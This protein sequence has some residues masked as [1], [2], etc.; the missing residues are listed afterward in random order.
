MQGDSLGLGCDGDVCQNPGLIASNNEGERALR[1]AATSKKDELRD[2]NTGGHRGLHRFPESN[3]D[4]GG[5]VALPHG[6][7][8]AQ[9]IALAEKDNY[10]VPIP[11]A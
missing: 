2:A 1:Y 4:N 11:I 5:S 6:A 10:P 3:R 9:T 8:I 7:Y